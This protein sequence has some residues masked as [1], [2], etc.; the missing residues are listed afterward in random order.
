M[1]GTEKLIGSVGNCAVYLGGEYLQVMGNK[2]GSMVMF[3]KG[4][5]PT[6][7]FSSINGSEMKVVLK[8]GEKELDTKV[9]HL[10]EGW[11]HSEMSMTTEEAKAKDA[12]P[13]TVTCDGQELKVLFAQFTPQG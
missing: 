2:K 1:S 11:S 8:R 6:L 9:G 7:T 5:Q 13:L 4:T 10:M 12:T 3:F